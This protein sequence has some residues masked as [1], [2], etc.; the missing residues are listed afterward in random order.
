MEELVQLAFEFNE[1]TLTESGRRVRGSLEDLAWR[2]GVKSTSHLK[3]IHH[4]IRY[5]DTVFRLP[6]IYVKDKIMDDFNN[7]TILV[8]IVVESKGRISK[9]QIGTKFGEQ[10]GTSISN[11]TLVRKLKD[12][13]VAV[14]RRRYKPM[15]TKTHKWTRYFYGCRHV[16]ERYHSWVDLDEK[17]FYVVR[18]KGFVWILPDF[19]DEKHIKRLPVQSKRYITKVMY[20][21]AVAR[22]VDRTV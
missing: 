12:L 4:E 7:Q 18:I 6:R 13:K 9:R 22:F 2:W 10:T 15:L 17:W 11:S 16:N 21:C 14:K 1:L 20:L 3:N 8:N 19:M 5:G